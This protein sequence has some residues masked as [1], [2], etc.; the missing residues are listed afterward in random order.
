M[1]EYKIITK[2]SCWS[3]RNVAQRL[4]EAI[5]NLAMKGW[6]LVTVNFTYY[7][8][9]AQATLVRDVNSKDFV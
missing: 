3:N 2:Y 1:K 6:D 5:N 7:G 8:Y 4:E 9:F